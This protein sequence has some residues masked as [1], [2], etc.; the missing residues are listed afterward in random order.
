MLLAFGLLVSTS[1]WAVP[2]PRIPPPSPPDDLRG[3]Y[4][5]F[6]EDLRVDAAGSPRHPRRFGVVKSYPDAPGPWALDTGLYAWDIKDGTVA[7]WAY[8]LASAAFV[9]R[10]VALAPTLSADHADL[11]L[12]L[13]QLYCGQVPMAMIC[14]ANLELR[15]GDEVIWRFADAQAADGFGIGLPDQFIASIRES[16]R[17]AEIVLP[18]PRE[19]AAPMRSL[20]V[21]WVWKGSERVPVTAWGRRD[22]EVCVDQDGDAQRF[23]ASAV[24]VERIELPDEDWIEGWVAVAFSG[25]PR[26]GRVRSLHGREYAW[27]GSRLYALDV[28]AVVGRGPVPLRANEFDRCTSSWLS[29]EE[30]GTVTARLPDGVRR[31]WPRLFSGEP[32]FLVALRP[33][34]RPL[35]PGHLNDI[36][37]GDFG[38]PFTLSPRRDA[39]PFTVLEALLTLKSAQLL[40][41]YER[42]LRTARTRR[43]AHGAV[44][45]VG[46]GLLTTGV[47]F[48]VA[49]RGPDEL[50]AELHA[51]MFGLGLTGGLLIGTNLPWF[52]VADKIVHDL[53]TGRVFVDQLDPRDVLDAAEAVSAQTK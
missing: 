15:R 37:L 8:R 7:D 43:D 41:D 42:A 1:A 17:D 6:V 11:V 30:S 4:R 38:V 29:P 33:D 18:E 31:R 3:P 16:L 5:L 26:F 47:V 52:A 23:N 44:L 51:T 53:G 34:G 25:R 19:R 21:A 9:E 36:L 39:E 40:T 12:T 20:D 27:F 14:D 49:T 28:Y 13:N 32:G 48:G 10:G 24:R 2:E 50:P 22:A 45:G 35:K 46:L